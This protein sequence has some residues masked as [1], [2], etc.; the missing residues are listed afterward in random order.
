[1]NR[2]F[3]SLALL[4]IL[5]FAAPSTLHADNGE[6]NL[7][8]E[9]EIFE[10]GKIGAQTYYV[11][12]IRFSIGTGNFMGVVLLRTEKDQP[13]I[14]FS[15][16]DDGEVSDAKGDK[17]SI[18]SVVQVLYHGINCLM[19]GSEEVSLNKDGFSITA[20][21]YGG[22]YESPAR[23]TDTWKKSG[24]R[25]QIIDHKKVVPYEEAQTAYYQLLKDGNLL[26]ARKLHLDPSPNGGWTCHADEYLQAYLDASHQLATEAYQSGR[27]FEAGQIALQ[28]LDAPPYEMCGND[29]EVKNYVFWNAQ[30]EHV[31]IHNG[32][33]RA[34]HRLKN[35][36]QNIELLNN[37]AFFLSEAGFAAQGI[38]FL[39]I[40]LDYSPQRL[41]AHL[42]LADSYWAVGDKGL[43]KKHYRRYMEL[44]EEGKKSSKIPS[45]V[46]VRAAK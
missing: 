37:L 33:G 25:F 11:H 22:R 1:M 8:D 14:S 38:H 24:D 4:L 16:N 34:S 17:I 5:L 39:K 41:V 9:A 15:V 19:F 26:E 27:I 43:A 6:F 29:N 44:H 42:N 3:P 35:K 12:S 23:I 36:S 13:D 30:G 32:N 46:S 28:A 10:M 45:R 2:I 20:T 21:R 18:P 7:K 40:V 31:T